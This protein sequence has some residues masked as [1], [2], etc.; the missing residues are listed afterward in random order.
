[1]PL[2]FDDCVSCKNRKKP[3]ICADCDFGEYF[4]DIESFQELD[5]SAE[6]SFDR[7]DTSLVTVDDEP[8]NNPDDL[9]RRV[10]EREE[11]EDDESEDE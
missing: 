5:F 11:P 7:A 3:R 10:T 4:E 6:R 9:I 1:M 8:D 2:K